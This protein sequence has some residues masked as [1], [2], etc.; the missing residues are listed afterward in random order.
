MALQEGV[1]V[2][3]R[4]SRRSTKAVSRF[5]PCAPVLAPLPPTLERLFGLI[6]QPVL[7]LNT[8]SDGHMIA[9]EISILLGS[10]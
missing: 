7:Q 8:A 6:S 1:G 2:V 5:E 9:R 3:V 4:R 10:T